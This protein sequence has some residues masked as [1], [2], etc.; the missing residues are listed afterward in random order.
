VSGERRP[1]AVD[2]RHYDLATHSFG[3]P[4]Q[5]AVAKKLDYE[6]GGPAGAIGENYTTGEVAVVWPDVA[7]ANH[8][9]NLHTSTDDGAH[10]SS[11]Q[12]IAH[13]GAG[14]ND[15]DNARVALAPNGTGFVTWE[16]TGGLHVAN[17][18][19]IS[20]KKRKAL[21]RRRRRRR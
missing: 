17:L 14:Y 19:P 15:W 8:E 16:D 18:K 21:R 20:P 3:A 6:T 9:L 12:D 5:L 4:T 1:A 13:I 2:V 7:G 11:A 10:F